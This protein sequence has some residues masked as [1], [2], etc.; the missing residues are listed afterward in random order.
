MKQLLLLRQPL[1]PTVHQWNWGLPT[2]LRTVHTKKGKKCQ[3][4]DGHRYSAMKDLLEYPIRVWGSLRVIIVSPLCNGLGPVTPV[5]L[6]DC[7]TPVRVRVS[8]IPIWYR[9]SL[10]FL[11][12]PSRRHRRRHPCTSAG[13]PPAPSPPLRRRPCSTEP[14]RPARAAGTPLPARRRSSSPQPTATHPL[15]SLLFPL[16][17]H[18]YRSKI[19]AVL[20]RICDGILAL[21]DSHLVPRRAAPPKAPQ[22]HRA[23]QPARPD[24]D[25]PS[26]LAARRSGRPRHCTERC[27]RRTSALPRTARAHAR[28]EADVQP[29]SPPGRTRA[30]G[31]CCA[32]SPARPDRHALVPAVPPR[33]PKPRRARSS[34]R[35][36]TAPCPCAFDTDTAPRTGLDTRRTRR[37][38][39][40]R[41]ARPSCSR[42]SSPRRPGAPAWRIRARLS[43]PRLPAPADRAPAPAALRPSCTAHHELYLARRSRNCACPPSRR[44]AHP[45]HVPILRSSL[46][47]YSSGLRRGP[48]SGGPSRAWTACLPTC[49]DRLP[50]G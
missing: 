34:P 44:P 9:A 12:S 28:Q 31:P 30:P 36:T 23:T 35:A 5:Y 11:P 41:A 25:R 6:I 4:A 40:A 29:P 26:A 14:R 20:A 8:V 24:P 27:C 48:P 13:R 43:S 33:R 50:S 7:P 22:G 39:P 38:L 47:P 21:L 32:A 19:E 16:S 15:S 42:P 18:A 46:E 2:N 10:F 49:C 37:A 45:G 3:F 17:I 1:A